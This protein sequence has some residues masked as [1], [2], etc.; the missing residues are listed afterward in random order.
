MAKVL[1]LADGPAT[2]VVE[3][4][5]NLLGDAHDYKV[6]AVAPDA[7]TPFLSEDSAAEAQ[8]ESDREF[9]EAA[10]E[11]AEAIHAETAVLSG[12]PAVEIVEAAKA[13]HAELIVLSESTSR[14]WGRIIRRSRADYVISHAPCAVLVLPRERETKTRYG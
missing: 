2:H 6:I 4:L 3:W 11:A 14:L 8:A 13:E 12:D 5:R 9:A 1:V 7:H 10:A